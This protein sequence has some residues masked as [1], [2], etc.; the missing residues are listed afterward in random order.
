M[1]SLL[2]FQEISSYKFKDVFILKEALTHRSY[3]AEHNLKYDNQRLEFLGDSVLQIILT[4]HL[5][6][7]YKEFPEGQLTKIRSAIAQQESL[8]ILAREIRLGEILYLGKGEIETGG[9]DRDS[10][11]ADAFEALLGAMY[12][13]GGLES[14]RTYLMAL[15]TKHFPEPSEL[16]QDL[17]PKGTLQEYTQKFF[18]ATPYYETV[19]VTGPDH[20]PSYTVKVFLKNQELGQG[21]AT[22]RKTAES[23]A[24]RQA[25]QTLMNNKTQQD[26]KTQ[27]TPA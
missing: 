1:N 12:L 23:N 9:R 10:T 2:K 16:L 5:F 3:S 27:D 18:N 20:N 8:A 6:N 21:S 7:L 22:K 24:A 26:Q 17:N 13:D 4:E 25:L 14:I 15:I 19:E 11:L